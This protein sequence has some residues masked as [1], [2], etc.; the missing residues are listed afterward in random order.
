LQL[1][2]GYPLAVLRLHRVLER[3]HRRQAPVAG[4]E[5]EL[6]P[7][8]VDDAEPGVLVVAAESDDARRDPRGQ[9]AHEGDDLLRLRAAIEVVAHEDDSVRLVELGEGGDEPEQGPCVAVDVADR[10][11]PVH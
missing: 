4:R 9:I 10:E 11:R 6:G 2:G 1:V 7:P 5:D 3:A 8:P